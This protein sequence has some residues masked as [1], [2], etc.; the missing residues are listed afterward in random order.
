MKIIKKLQSYV[1]PDMGIPLLIALAWNLFVFY[2][3]RPITASRHH[4]DMTTAFDKWMP[5]IPWTVIIYFSCYIFWALNYILSCYQPRKE[6]YRFLSAHFLAETA[7]LVLFIALP[8]TLSRPEGREIKNVFDRLLAYL[9]SIDSADNLFPSL[10][11]LVS[12]MCVIGVRNNEIVPK[13]YKIFSYVFTLMI[14]ITVLTTKQH[15]A[16]DILSGVIIA[17]LSYR[18]TDKIGLTKLFEK[19]HCKLYHLGP[20]TES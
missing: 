17:E 9:Y 20:T 15:V 16:A 10:H 2:F 11:C 4:F 13:W 14:F 1:P 3:P 5:V 12:W 18:F 19:I 6:S 8:T 7:A